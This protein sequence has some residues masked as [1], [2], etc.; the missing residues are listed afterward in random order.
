MTK[1]STLE[2]SWSGFLRH[3][4]KRSVRYKIAILLAGIA[5]VALAYY[6]EPR[7]AVASFGVAILA[8]V[9]ASFFL[10]IFPTDAL[11]SRVKAAGLDDIFVLSR[12]RSEDAWFGSL[13]S[14]ARQVDLM[15]RSLFKWVNTG[16]RRKRF[17]ETLM[18]LLEKG[19]QVR[20]LLMSR[21]N[22]YLS[23]LEEQGKP[24]Y[25]SLAPK[26]SYVEEYLESLIRKIPQDSRNQLKVRSN[27]SL[28]FYRSVARFDSTLFTVGYLDNRETGECP[29]LEIEGYGRPLFDLYSQMFEDAWRDSRHRELH[30]DGPKKGGRGT[31]EDHLIRHQQSEHLTI[32]RGLMEESR[33]RFHD[34]E[35][36]W[37]YLFRHLLD[38]DPP[39]N[40]LRDVTFASAS[41][42]GFKG[43]EFSSYPA[44]VAMRSKDYDFSIRLMIICDVE[45]TDAACLRATEQYIYD[46]IRFS[47]P[48]GLESSLEDA[49]ALLKESSSWLAFVIVPFTAVKSLSFRGPFN[50]YGD[51]AVSTSIIAEPN[52]SPRLEVSWSPELTNNRISQFETLWMQYRHTQQD[53]VEAGIKRGSL[54]GSVIPSLDLSPKSSEAEG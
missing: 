7:S 21:D 2:S 31:F 25:E 16:S 37:E 9:F 26:L 48:G 41:R 38:L 27:Y 32:M 13:S 22:R 30:G 14:A 44:R 39:V 17:E 29:L 4:Q 47:R 40:V 51:V 46:F 45:N 3:L 50:V 43:Y 42:R 28:P 20:I 33:Y 34:F 15:G 52:S 5:M 24:L 53:F 35:E 19:V 54:D 49:S 8:S 11:D 6:S 1:E 18:R 10:Q 23:A 12:S 36:G